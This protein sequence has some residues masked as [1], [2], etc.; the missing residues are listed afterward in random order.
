MACRQT[1]ND[2]SKL[3]RW[4]RCLYQLALSYDE[5]I[6]LKCIGKATE[7]AAERQGVSDLPF[8]TNVDQLTLLG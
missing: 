4:I 5:G 6:S 7:I 1:G 8:A 3:S 2:I